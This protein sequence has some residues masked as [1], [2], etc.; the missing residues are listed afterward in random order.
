MVHNYYFII[1]LFR[2]LLLRLLVSTH[3][4]GYIYSKP[5]NFCVYS[6]FVRFG[7]TVNA[8]YLYSVLLVLVSFFLSS[9]LYFFYKKTDFVYCTTHLAFFFIIKL[10]Y[11]VSFLYSCIFLFSGYSKSTLYLPRMFPLFS[12][13]R[14]GL[15]GLGLVFLS[16][17][18][19]SY[20]SEM[21]SNVHF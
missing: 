5:S 8:L 2:K 17:K 6:L 4:G 18:R 7:F 13:R 10:A 14:I 21:V 11:L 20:G 1:F 19:G 3:G 12:Y 9:H 16:I 15:S